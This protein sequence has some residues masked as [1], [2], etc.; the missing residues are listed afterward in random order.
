VSEQ[1]Y[2]I[3]MVPKCAIAQGSSAVG[4]ATFNPHKKV[5]KTHF[6]I[7]LPIPSKL[8]VSNTYNFLQNVKF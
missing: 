6:N 5:P 3:P 4:T 2:S 8:R 7:I 1:Q